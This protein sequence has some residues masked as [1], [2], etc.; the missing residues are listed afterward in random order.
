MCRPCRS[1]WSTYATESV[2]E[3]FEKDFMNREVC[4]Y[5][6][7]DRGKALVLSGQTSAGLKHMKLAW[8]VGY[9][10]NVIH[11]DMAVFLTRSWFL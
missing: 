3:P 8:E 2:Y 1:V 10:D 5:F 4:A 11:S 6:F 7:F 9:N